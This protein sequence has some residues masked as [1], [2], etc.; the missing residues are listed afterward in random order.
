MQKQI[1][2]QALLS[3]WIVAL[4]ATCGEGDES[5]EGSDDDDNDS[6]EMPEGVVEGE[7]GYFHRDAIE[8]FSG[9]TKPRKGETIFV[10]PEG[11]DENDGLSAANPLKTFSSALC[12]AR[13]GQTIKVLP[14][15][16]EESVIIVGFGEE[17]SPI[18]IIGVV[19]GGKKP[20]FDGGGW[21]TMGIGIAE[22]RNFIIENIEFRNYTDEG[23]SVIVSSE[24]EIRG[25]VFTKNGFESINPD[26]EGEG[27][28]VLISDVSD[29]VVEDN[30]AF[31]NGPNEKR[32]KDGLLGTAI[33]LFNVE[34]GLV[35]G[36]HAYNNFGCG[37]LIE[38][39]R[40]VLVEDN[41][42]NDNELNA[43]GDYWD[44]G[45]W[46]DGGYN[47]KVVGN[48]IHNNKGPGIQVSD[49]EIKYP[50]ESC[51][52]EISGNVIEDN[53]WALF[54][55]NFGAC[56]LPPENALI[57]EDNDVSGNSYAGD[58]EYSIDA[59]YRDGEILCFDWPCGENQPCVDNSDFVPGERVCEK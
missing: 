26:A 1:L 3:V 27:F 46:L 44:S 22:S 10:S 50:Y 32:R 21:L 43:A 11:S 12:N 40:D 57:Y 17:D 23:L 38:D 14:G 13:A 16:Y 36:N 58:D 35:R 33:N 51:L 6:T 7:S 15:I 25:N 52:Y 42:V 31:D 54:V 8:C 55:N 18:S 39:S 30:E 56:P 45:I 49:T 9:D 59:T 4:F 19:E 5:E 2:L 20:I 41:E 48:N 34:D 24:I 53:Y 37:I 28:G 29:F 47:V